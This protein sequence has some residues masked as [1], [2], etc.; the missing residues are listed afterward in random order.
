MLLDAQQGE[1]RTQAQLRDLERAASDKLA[2][3]LRSQELRVFLYRLTLTLPLLGV[4]GWLF[5]RKRKSTWW[6]FVL[7]LHLFRAVR[8]LRRAGA[9]FAQLRWLC[10]LRGGDR[11]LP[12][13]SGVTRS[14]R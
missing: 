9:L 8:I 1:A 5:A 7:G 11:H 3:E 2:T 12:C 14:L 10:A 4:A 13:W 6:P